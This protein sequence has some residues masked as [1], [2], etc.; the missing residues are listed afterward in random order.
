MKD[1]IF[2]YKDNKVMCREHIRC[3]SSLNPKRCFCCGKFV[4]DGQKVRL[5]VNN[6]NYFPN[7][8]IHSYCFD[9]W[10]GNEEKLFSD[11]EEVYNKYKELNEIF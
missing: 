8:L 3:Y 7:V 10:K 11:I 5:L 4:E 9:I 6:Y 2:K 1:N